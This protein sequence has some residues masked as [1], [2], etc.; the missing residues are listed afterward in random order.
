MIQWVTDCLAS[1]I[2]VCM[3]VC[4]Y[5]LCMLLHTYI[6]NSISNS[7]KSSLNFIILH[8]I[9]IIQTLLDKGYPKLVVEYCV[10][11]DAEG[12]LLGTRTQKCLISAYLR[13]ECFSEAM[14]VLDVIER[15]EVQV[16]SGVLQV[17]QPYRDVRDALRLNSNATANEKDNSNKDNVNYINN[18][19]LDNKNTNDD[20]Y[21]KLKLENRED[22]TVSKENKIIFLDPLEY[23]NQ[24][25]ARFNDP[26][27][28][29]KDK[30]KEELFFG[31][32]LFCFVI[33]MTSSSLRKNIVNTR[34]LNSTSTS[35]SVRALYL[36]VI[37]I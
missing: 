7:L 14:L 4:V 1:W 13:L 26:N 35:T 24:N 21:E 15:E 25:M 16:K 32:D 23:R 11:A 36:R 18:D 22:C 19:T 37:F 34:L 10:K 20:N 17:L 12:F 2:C 27:L 28:K 31:L 30:E 9:I 6:S 8:L 29:D 3:C 5:V 33:L